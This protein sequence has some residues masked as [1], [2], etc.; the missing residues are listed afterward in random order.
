MAAKLTFFP[1]SPFARIARV[2]V[3]EWSLPVEPEQWVF[4]PDETSY[5]ANPLGQVPALI[6]DNGD[7]LFPTLVILEHMWEMAG[8]PAEVYQPNE[9]RQTLLTVLSA[10]DALVTAKYIGWTGLEPV[11]ENTVNFDLQGRNFERFGKTL[12]WLDA[13][14]E[15]GSLGG[16]T[17]LIGVAVA[18]LVLWADAR[19]GPEWRGRSALEAVVDDLAMRASFKATTPPP[20]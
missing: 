5:A 9:H 6:L 15:D 4:P 10:G 16:G 8:K 13:K 2:L 1:G 19:G 20:W 7:A 17:T 11:G 3:E 18:A 14:F 12:D